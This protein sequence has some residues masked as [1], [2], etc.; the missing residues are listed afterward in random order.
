MLCDIP[1]EYSDYAVT[2]LRWLV[3]AFMTLQ[4]DEV[5]EVVAF[6]LAGSPRFDPDARFLDNR[7]LVDICSG[8]VQ[9]EKLS[10]SQSKFVKLAHYSVKEY[11]IAEKRGIQRLQRYS[12]PAIQSHQQI[13]AACLVYL[14][15]QESLDPSKSTA[16]NYPLLIYARESWHSH[17]RNLG[18]DLGNVEDLSLQ[19]LRWGSN[20]YDTWV[21]H[22]FRLEPS[23]SV[24]LSPL[25]VMAAFG[26]PAIVESLVDAGHDVNERCQPQSRYR[27]QKQPRK[28]SRIHDV[29]GLEDLEH[30]TALGVASSRRS[31]GA[32]IRLLLRLGADPNHGSVDHPPV[33]VAAMTGDLEGLEALIESGADLHYEDQS[34]CSALIAA[35]M[36]VDDDSDRKATFLLDRGANVHL[37]SQVFGNALHAACA[38]PR[39]NLELV[40]VLVSRGADI[41]AQ[42]GKYG[43]AFQAACAH[44][45]NDKVI[46]FLLS[47]ADPH[48]EV[49]NS[50]YGTP[51]QALC[52]ESHDNHE[53]A[54]LL[55]K[56]GAHR[57]ARG[58]KYGTAL[59]AACSQRNREIVRVLLQKNRPDETVFSDEETNVN[60]KSGKYGSALHAACRNGDSEMVTLLLEAGARVNANVGKFG[61]PLHVACS[62]QNN[63]RNNSVVQLLLEHGADIHILSRIG[64]HSV[65]GTILKCWHTPDLIST[66]ILRMLYEYDV[67]ETGLSP[68]E[69]KD[70]IKLK[71]L[72]GIPT[73][74]QA[75]R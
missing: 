58:G 69:T 23:V 68:D 74:D 37:T 6:E 64:G 44:G 59:Q 21:R 2:I 52:A 61:T 29:F 46:R 47:K 51:L 50:K 43:T 20:P 15:H 35:C 33:L 39:A 28:K 11:L 72:A 1:E 45:G 13:A 8:F 5:G 49:Q 25:Y 71:R 36:S 48:I 24:Q 75:G 60:L 4:L 27:Y 7:D 57:N 32:V 56:H 55:L 41:N 18:P 30:G 62:F 54:R 53:M 38:K 34:H 26:V 10:I 73:A 17:A 22:H 67:V 42:S 40:R 16:A 19:F 65:L 70:L 12:L 3:Y 66:E 9:M 63:F 31:N 14:L